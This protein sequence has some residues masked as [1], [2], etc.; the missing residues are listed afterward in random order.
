MKMV[1]TFESRPPAAS[2]EMYAGGER[3]VLIREELD[4]RGP[5]AV[6]TWRAFPGDGTVRDKEQRIPV[7][8]CLTRPNRGTVKTVF[9]RRLALP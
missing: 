3:F 4:P 6:L 1:T 9:R 8:L 2:R 5:E 7:R